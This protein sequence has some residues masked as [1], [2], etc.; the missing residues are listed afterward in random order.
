MLA[1]GTGHPVQRAAMVAGRTV[2]RG[3]A[4]SRRARTPKSWSWM[5]RQ[6]R[7]ASLRPAPRTRYRDAGLAA[8]RTR[9][10]RG[11]RRRRTIQPVRVRARRREP[12]AAAA[13][14]I[15]PVARPGRTSRRTG[16]RLS[17]SAT[18]STASIS[19]RCRIQPRRPNRCSAAVRPARRRRSLRRPR[20]RDADGAAVHPAADADAD[21]VAAGHR[22][23]GDQLARRARASAASMCSATTPTAPRRPGVSTRLPFTGRRCATA[24][25]DSSPTPTT[26]GVPT[27]FASASGR[28]RS[29]G[30]PTTEAAAPAVDPGALA[31]DS[32]PDCCVP[33]RRV[34][35]SHQALASRHPHRRPVRA[36]W[37]SRVSLNRTA[38]RVGWTTSSAQVFGFSISP[39]RRRHRRRP[40]A[41]SAP[42]RAR[43][44][45]LGPRLTGDVRAYL[46]GARP[47]SRRRP[48]RRGRRVHRRRDGAPAVPARR[49]GAGRRR[50]RLRTPT[51]SACCAAFEPNAFAGTP[52]R[53]RERR[54]PLAARA[55]AARLRHAGRCFCTRVHAAVFADAGHAWIG[56]VR[57][58]ATSRS[59]LGGE[60]SADVVAGY[61]L[62]LTVDGRRRVGTRRH[63]APRDGAT[64]YVRVG[65][66]F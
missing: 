34:R 26:A 44:D 7:C 64:V 14:A 40:P 23:D 42:R 29:P 59:S 41:K 62:P 8:R 36:D 22:A 30:W 55:A 37:R 18:P 31:R 58:S 25:L 63:G 50:P 54:L 53:A 52:R 57:A 3:R 51:R 60:L 10:R 13:D 48:A 6:A 66:A 19:S 4:A 33:F 1:V 24:R 61:S 27:L 32:K 16:R 20:F 38:A 21:V 17:S 39:E 15:R 49:R 28:R 9:D 5:P 56:R 45:G 46:P 47:Q 2:D 35:M 65:R 43:L 12:G 11:R